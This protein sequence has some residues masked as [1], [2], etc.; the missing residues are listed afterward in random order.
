MLY[1]SGMAAATAVFLS[2]APGDHVIAP[3][4]MYWSL[5]NWLVTF[6]RPSGLD[7]EL[8][9]MADTGALRAAIRKGKTKLVWAET[10]ANPT[11]DITDLAAAAEIAH[12]AEGASRRRFH[13]RLAGAHA[14][15]QT[16]RRYRDA[17]GDEISER[18]FR[19]NRRRARHPRR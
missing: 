16:W 17:F 9:D 14:S 5:R 3:K 6:A 7:V 2:L 11:W 12:A 4:V 18:P 19:P 13:R 8:V 15:A 10:P 1:S